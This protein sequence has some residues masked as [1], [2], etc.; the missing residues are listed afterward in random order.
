MIKFRG[1]GGK[2][3]HWDYNLESFTLMAGLAACTSRIKLFASTA[4]LA[5]PPAVCARMAVTVDNIADSTA[6]SDEYKGRFGVNMVTGW[7][8]AEFTQMG[9]WPGDQYF[10]YRYDYAEEYVRVMK[11]LWHEGQCD[12]EGKYFNMKDCRLEPRP[13]KDIKIICAGQS[14]RGTRFAAEWSDYNFTNGKGINTPTAFAQGNERLVE[15]AKTSGRDVGAMVGI[16]HLLRHPWFDNFDR[17]CSCSL[18]M[19]PT[20]ALKPSGSS[21]AKTWTRKQ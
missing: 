20:R 6:E 15:A 1:F 3:E 13:A 4:V 17:F 2:T 14:D 19:R 8:S 18:W 7:Q 16:P 21:T 10:G 9:L 12:F 5:L 11:T